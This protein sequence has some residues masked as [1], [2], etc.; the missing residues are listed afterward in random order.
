MVKHLGNDKEV[1]IFVNE[2][3]RQLKIHEK[4][5]PSLKFWSFEDVML[6]NCPEMVKR[7]NMIIDA[8]VSIKNDLLGENIKENLELIAKQSV[9]N[10]N[11]SMMCYLKAIEEL[12][13]FG[14]VSK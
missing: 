4:D 5:K 6:N 13:K 3:K 11:Y 10:A 8:N 12:Q 9:H 7:V 1:S 2:M 14:T